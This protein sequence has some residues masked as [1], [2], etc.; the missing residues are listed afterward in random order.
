MAPFRVGAGD[1]GQVLS[2]SVL[3]HLQRFA[4][5]TENSTWDLL[6]LGDAKITAFPGLHSESPRAH[7]HLG[8]CAGLWRCRQ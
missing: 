4:L 1:G 6:V 3:Q 5:C 7:R 8:C 2:F